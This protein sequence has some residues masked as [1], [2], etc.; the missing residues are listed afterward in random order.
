MFKATIAT[1][2]LQASVRAM[3]ALMEE[4][5]FV[6]TPDGMAASAVDPANSAMA[7]IDLSSTV[8]SAFDATDSEI[9]VDLRRFVEVL[10]MS[11]NNTSVCLELDEHTHKLKIDMGGLSYDLAL[12]DPTSMRKSPNVPQLDLP[13]QI[14]LSSV[15]FKRAIKAASMTADHLRMGV[16]GNVFVM[17]AKGDSDSVR[18]EIPESE[19]ITLK[20]ADV[21]ALYAL[22]Y[23]SDISKGIGTA[24]EI[25]INLGRDLPTVINFESSGECPVRYIL[26]P[27]IESD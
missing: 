6:M 12:L 10:S 16:E 27:R 14:T 2:I 7:T 24:Q 17:L 26:A 19:L 23:L 21:S 15:D 11:S 8:F 20:A 13:A 22:D 5:I 9:G 18:L 25:V 1:D 3:S 4:C